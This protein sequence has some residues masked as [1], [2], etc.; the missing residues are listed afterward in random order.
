[1]GQKKIESESSVAVHPGTTTILIGC[2]GEVHR[3]LL[4]T[5]GTG[6]RQNGCAYRQRQNGLVMLRRFFWHSKIYSSSWTPFTLFLVLFNSPTDNVRLGRG[7]EFDEEIARIGEGLGS[8]VLPRD[9]NNLE[10][11]EV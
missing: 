5:E 8:R 2:L 3:W 9:C 7:L 4:S 11:A 10:E 6:R 1:M